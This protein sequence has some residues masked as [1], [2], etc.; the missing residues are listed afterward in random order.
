MK[1]YA[2]ILQ[3]STYS[4]LDTFND[5]FTRALNTILKELAVSVRAVNACS[6]TLSHTCFHCSRQKI[7]LSF[8][9]FFFLLL[10][11]G[12]KKKMNSFQ[13]T[14][15]TVSNSYLHSGNF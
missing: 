5:F 13:I 3:Y 2:K 4:L 14:V 11:M 10:K 1:I 12:F 15:V 8:E 7:L 9:M 6:N